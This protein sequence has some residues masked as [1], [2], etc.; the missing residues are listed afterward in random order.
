MPFSGV[1]GAGG[2]RLVNGRERTKDPDTRHGQHGEGEARFRRDRVDEGA[3]RHAVAVQQH[4]H[5][6]PVPHPGLAV[7]GEQQHARHDGELDQQRVAVGGVQ[8]VVQ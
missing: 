6:E 7:L 5:V 8:Q 1:G 4:R 3:D 2:F